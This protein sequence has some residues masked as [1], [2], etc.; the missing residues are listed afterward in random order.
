MDN[1]ELAKLLDEIS[2][3]LRKSNDHDHGVMVECRISQLYLVVVD[4]EDNSTLD[5]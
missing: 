1:E 4:K 2:I 3:E 5:T